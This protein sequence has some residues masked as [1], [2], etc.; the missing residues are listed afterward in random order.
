MDP[1]ERSYLTR[2]AARIVCSILMIIFAGFLIGWFFLKAELDSVLPLEADQTL[3]HPLVKTVTYYWIAALLVIFGLLAL[4]AIDLV[5]TARHG[6]RS[7]RRLAT[8]RQAEIEEDLARPAA[9]GGGRVLR[10]MIGSR[11]L[12]AEE[13]MD[14]FASR[15]CGTIA[16]MITS[17][18]ASRTKPA[19]SSAGFTPADRRVAPAGR[20]RACSDRPFVDR[21]HPGGDGVPADDGVRHALIQCPRRTQQAARALATARSMRSRMSTPTRRPA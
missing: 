1:A 3:E 19:S 9:A 18:S 15:A 16:S 21:R 13:E 6:F 12:P 4:A 14:R 20:H 8:Q 2:C 7:V 10:K 17:G 5:A 11:L